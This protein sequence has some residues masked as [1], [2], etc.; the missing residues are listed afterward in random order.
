VNLM[1]RTLSKADTRP[2]FTPIPS[3]LLQRKCACGGSVGLDGECEACRSKR[4][5]R[6]AQND[7]S[8]A[9][10]PPIVHEVLHSPG[11]PLDLQTR[12]F[13][14][15]RF[16]HDFSKVRVHTDE[17][18]AESA[19]AVNALAYTV[20]SDVVFRNNHYQ[21]RSGSGQNLLAHELTHVIQQDHGN[22]HGLASASRH[23][24]SFEREADHVAENMRTGQSAVPNI[25]ASGLALRRD[26]APGA[27]TTADAEQRAQRAELGCRIGELCG[28][29]QEAP[30]VVT[31]ERIRAA[32]QSCFPGR[33]TA[34]N[35]CLQPQFVLPNFGAPSPAGPFATQ[36]AGGGQSAGSGRSL[37]DSEFI[38]SVRSAINA[39]TE[40]ITLEHR[41]GRLN[42]SVRGATG[43]LLLGRTTVGANVGPGGVEAKTQVGQLNV[44]AS[45]GWSG[46]LGISTSYRGWHFSGSLSSEQ[47][48][49]N[50]SYPL[51]STPPNLGEL[52]RIFQEGEGA[53]RSIA[54]DAVRF[55]RLE[56]F[57]NIPKSHGEQLS[58]VKR[59]IQSASAIAES[60]ATNISFGLS[61]R[62]SRRTGAESGSASEGVEVMGTVTWRF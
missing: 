50:L 52:G 48:T 11:Q 59:A 39:L 44:G 6:R 10:V 1:T 5:Q 23:D 31:D 56:D 46:N 21:P 7:F 25:S 58:Q 28:M 27:A 12:M 3:G 60:R 4:L 17:K 35:P 14:E 9:T 41:P 47:W 19:Q 38:S 45:I 8:P 33:L 26:E 30:T 34:L 32:V 36:P 42:V 16:G 15:P 62:G 43:Q 51:G 24:A 2:S 29:R 54:R 49:L 18:A 53:I 61:A 55:R 40:G 22:A 13:F 37:V 20:G 57:T